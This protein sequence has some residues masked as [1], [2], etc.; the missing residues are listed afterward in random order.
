M[1]YFAQKLL[2]TCLRFDL[3]SWVHTRLLKLG[4]KSVTALLT[5]KRLKDSGYKQNTR[6]YKFLYLWNYLWCDRDV[7]SPKHCD[8]LSCQLHPNLNLNKEI[9][10]IR[11][12]IGRCHVLKITLLV[13]LWC[14]VVKDC[15]L[16]SKYFSHLLQLW[17]TFPMKEKEDQRKRIIAYFLYR[18]YELFPYRGWL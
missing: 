18:C 16:T 9:F 13:K 15:N 14:V 10:I 17:V 12:T 6:L 5:D 7:S 8:E 4:W 11:Y 1:P 2:L 3:K